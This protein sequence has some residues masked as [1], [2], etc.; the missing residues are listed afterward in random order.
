MR[1]FYR[2]CLFKMIN[3]PI[4]C[5]IARYKVPHTHQQKNPRDS[6]LLNSRLPPCPLSAS[7]CRRRRQGDAGRPSSPMFFSRTHTHTHTHTRL[8]A[9]ITATWQHS[10][11]RY[12]SPMTIR[13]VITRHRA[14]YLQDRPM[15]RMDRTALSR[16]HWGAWSRPTEYPALTF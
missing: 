9:N 7:L 11:P 2:V 15:L 8:L 14:S 5:W 6:S 10:L 12:T 16:R 1:Q 13:V 3:S 4:C